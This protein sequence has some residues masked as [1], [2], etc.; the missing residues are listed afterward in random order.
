ML[1]KAKVNIRLRGLA[2]FTLKTEYAMISEQRSDYQG[3]NLH[4]SDEAQNVHCYVL[5]RV[6]C[7]AARQR[8]K[9][10]LQQVIYEIIIYFF[11]GLL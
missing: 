6:I 10:K 5:Q 11:S 1:P 4:F 8:L 7:R 9:G 2:V 3:Q